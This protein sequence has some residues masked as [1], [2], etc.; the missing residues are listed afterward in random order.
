M[1][2]HLVPLLTCGGCQYR[3]V[4][5]TRRDETLP[6]LRRQ[7]ST[8]MGWSHRRALVAIDGRER[9]VMVDLCPNC[10]RAHLEV[11][12]EKSVSE[13]GTG[14][15]PMSAAELTRS[16]ADENLDACRVRCHVCGARVY[17][18]ETAHDVEPGDDGVERFACA[19]H[20]ETCR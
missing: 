1:T 16:D 2:G 14:G 5:A 17:V 6:Q 13:L 8:L 20:C 15:A 4:P 11:V 19:E 18:G 9:S 7:A 3:Q 10:P 12:A